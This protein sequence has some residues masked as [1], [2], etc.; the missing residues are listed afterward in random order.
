MDI[1][2]LMIQAVIA[3][4]AMLFLIYALL[5]AR[6]VR[7]ARKNQAVRFIAMSPAQSAGNDDLPMVTVLLP[8][9]NE[10]LIVH[11]IIDAACA[12][13][14]PKDRLEILLLDDSTDETSALAQK[15]IARYSA[16]GVPIRH[17]RREKRIGYKAGNLRFG[18]TLARGEFIAIF[19]ADCLPPADFLLKVMPCFADDRVGFLQTG[20][21]HVNRK[22][23]FLT[24]F[25]AMEAGHKEDVTSGLSR[26]GLMASLTGTSCVWR[27]SCIEAIGGISTATITED[28][29]MGYAAQL[30]N[31]KYVWLR[32]VTSKA[33]FPESMAAFRVQRQRWARGLIQNA[34]R[35]VRQMFATS[36]PLLARLYALSL[37]F[38]SLLLAAFFCVLLLCLP[39][40]LLFRPGLFFHVCCTLFLGAALVWAWFNTVN[41]SAGAS[42]CRRLGS[43]LGYVV[44]HFPL[45]LYYFS[46]AVQVAAG[47]E[48]EFYRTP[49]G[50]GRQKVR[51]PAINTRLVWLELFS[52]CYGLASFG[53]GLWT[54]NYWISLY[55]GLASA[56]FALTLFFSWSDSRKRFLPGSV[57]ITGATG[58][59]GSALALE[60]AAPGMQL[61]LLGRRQ[62]VL[63]QLA[64]RCRARGADVQ[65]HALDLREADELRRW[66]SAC[67][68]EHTPDLI[69]ANA[70]LNTNIGPHGK[71]EPFADVRSLV[72]VNLLSVMALVDGAL[73]ALRKRG[74]GQLA[75]VS[76]LAAYYGLPATP[77]Y[78]ATKAGLKAYGTSLRGWLRSEHIRVSVILP[79]YVSSPMCAAMPGPKPFLWPPER[80][81]RRIRRGL[82]LDRARIS[83]PFPLNLGIWGLS[84]LPACLAMPIARM[85]GYDR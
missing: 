7:N 28:V 16:K 23:T 15:R 11:K 43:A 31:W 68:A 81:A 76:S 84:L 52:L 17:A 6:S 2:F 29:D 48:G 13:Q 21:E 45:S 83:F 54:G 57:L 42:F 18:L 58:A 85:F 75:I 14:Y 80:A 49:K 79:G 41:G 20:I 26:E 9:Y 61:I 40:G 62:D 12:L 77:T 19:D 78:C 3:L 74:G 60:Y 69:I 82:A 44:M 10:R 22:A 66:I 70:G 1:F 24:R 59:L 5:E 63:E 25:Q 71:G 72:E 50:C 38:S 37:M 73:P 39:M 34:A 65:T 51:H 46:A 53:V 64:V 4:L 30:E 55:S 27:R 33:E 67:C 32:D 47:H 35:H 36:M 8:V 56:G